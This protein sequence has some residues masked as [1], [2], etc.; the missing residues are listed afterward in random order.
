[1]QIFGLQITFREKWKPRVSLTYFSMVEYAS[2]Y[3]A[4]TGAFA[5]M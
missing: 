4:Q 2:I 5:A 1:M 3:L